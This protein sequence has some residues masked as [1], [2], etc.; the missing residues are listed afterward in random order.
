MTCMTS[1]IR[2]VS[3][4]N[5]QF[6]INI[7]KCFFNFFVT[8]QIHTKYLPWIHVQ[9]HKIRIS[10]AFSIAVERFQ[11]GIKNFEMKKV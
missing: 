3:Y 7:E 1:R 5:R 11:N 6:L 9:M 10:F 4:M 8:Q 2:K